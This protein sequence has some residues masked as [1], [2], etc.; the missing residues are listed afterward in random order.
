[1]KTLFL[2]LIVLISG[3]GTVGKKG[4][5]VM[6]SQ[7]N[8]GGAY[9]FFTGKVDYCKATVVGDPAGLEVT[10]SDKTKKCIVKYKF[11]Q[12]ATGGET[13]SKSN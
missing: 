3:C 8:G 1:M 5:Y 13:I 10:Y 11:K 7:G 9:S 2:L 12:E 6:V 4:D